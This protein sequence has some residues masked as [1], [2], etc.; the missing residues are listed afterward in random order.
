ME[1]R[2]LVI[3]QGTGMT[4]VG[5]AGDDMPLL[6]LPTVM[7]PDE[8]HSDPHHSKFNFN[9]KR[10]MRMLSSL[11]FPMERGVVDDWDMM[12]RIYE[13]IYVNQK[14]NTAPEN[15]PLLISEACEN[16]KENRYH[17][18][19]ILF[20]KYKVP[21][22]Y[23]ASQPVL[24]L[25]ST[26]KSSGLVVE[27]GHGVSQTVPIFEGF[28]L[29]H[30]IVKSEFGGL[31][32]TN[33]LRQ[34]LE[35]NK[36]YEE[37][38]NYNTIAGYKILTEMKEKLCYISQNI[39]EEQYNVGLSEYVLPDRKVIQIT[40]EAYKCPEA[41]FYPKLAGKTNMFGVHEALFHVYDKSDD[42]IKQILMDNIVLAG[43][44]T[45]FTGFKERL[46]AE[47]SRIL[48]EKTG[49]SRITDK[50][51]RAENDRVFGSWIGGSILASLPTVQN[52]WITR[53]E[54]DEHH[55]AIFSRCYG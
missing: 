16:P 55:D 49:S 30:A 1:F 2:P 47:F 52:L 50:N 26:G 22:I 12:E 38:I 54:Y 33:Y 15:Q 43:G 40:H 23:I 41:L 42:Y 21:S 5:F 29:Y 37:L 27:I 9:E 51:V 11:H 6:L 7:A 28:P 53:Q 46:I 32:I 18:A 13:S 3:D 8:L 31:D 48:T 24:S 4:K 14:I 19:E 45:M 10:D 44:S 17:M 25:Y 20:E 36:R 39:A 35:K 34:L